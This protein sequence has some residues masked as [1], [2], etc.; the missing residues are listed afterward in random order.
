MTLGDLRRRNNAGSDVICPGNACLITRRSQVQILPPLLPRAPKGALGSCVEPPSPARTPGADSCIAVISACDVH[1]RLPARAP[2]PPP[3]AS[4]PA[5]VRARSLWTVTFAAPR[6]EGKN[7]ASRDARNGDHGRTHG[8]Q[9]VAGR[10]RRR[11][12]ESHSGE[13]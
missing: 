4:A 11:G 13:G 8:E 9:L 6:K 7:G 2:L 12:L 5:A 3:A 10:A 1:A